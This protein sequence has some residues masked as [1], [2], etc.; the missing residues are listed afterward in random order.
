MPTQTSG[1]ENSIASEQIPARTRRA[2]EAA[3]VVVPEGNSTGRFEVYSAKAGS[4]STYEVDLRERVCSCPDHE[5]REPAGGCKHARRVRL[6]LGLMDI[7]AGFDGELDTALAHAREQYAP[8]PEQEPEPTQVVPDGGETVEKPYTV[9]MEPVE[10]GGGTYARC[11]GCSREILPVGRFDK[12]P[13]ADG[14]PH[15]HASE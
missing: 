8:E 6:S 3:M 1:T 2:L 15:A 4:N 12:L 11:T 10:Q 5:H 9:H 7:P 14:C 13:H